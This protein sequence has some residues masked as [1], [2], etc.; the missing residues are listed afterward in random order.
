[1]RI[2]DGTSTPLKWRRCKLFYFFFVFLICTKTLN[3][4][5]NNFNLFVS[6]WCSTRGKRNFSI[7]VQRA[8]WTWNL[9]WYKCV[10]QCMVRYIPLLNTQDTFGNCQRPVFSVYLNFSK[11]KI[12]RQS[13]ERIMEEKMPLSHKLCA[14]RW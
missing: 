6:E 3:C 4:V 13:C 12:G 10:V 7:F 9:I 11:K 2:Y 14:F 5:N 1:M 8:K